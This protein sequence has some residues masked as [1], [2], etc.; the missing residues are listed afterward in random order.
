M[1]FYVL[2]FSSLRNF[3]ANDF[4]WEI[5]SVFGR[6]LLMNINVLSLQEYWSRIFAS[7][8][9]SDSFISLSSL[10]VPLPEVP[11]SATCWF[12]KS[13]FQWILWFFFR[14]YLRSIQ[15][16]KKIRSAFLFNVASLTSVGS[17][18]NSSAIAFA[19][20]WVFPPFE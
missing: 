6:P 11:N 12:L 17:I 18:V 4:A 19:I 15:T 3:W 9:C 1:V 16:L 7:F 13:F 5:S 14:V 2:L 20:F 8:F 10:P